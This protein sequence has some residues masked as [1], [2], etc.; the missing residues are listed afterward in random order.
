MRT[1]DFIYLD[2]QPELADTLPLNGVSLLSQ[3]RVTGHDGDHNEALPALEF[4][5]TRFDP[6][7][8]D[9]FPVQGID[10]PARSLA[11]PDLELADLL[12]NGLP[13]I[14]QLNGV[15]RYWRNLGG[16]RFDLPCPMRD[17][18]AE[19]LPVTGIWRDQRR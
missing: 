10:L 2:Q 8:R 16:G 4:G 19:T 18:P 5:Y 14:V 17:A 1:Y 15:A 6:Q 3:V 12:G 11:S 7:R 13:D 9:F